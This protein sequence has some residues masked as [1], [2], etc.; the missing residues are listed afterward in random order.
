MGRKIYENSF[1]L[2]AVQHDM[3][4]VLTSTR[5]VLF[6]SQIKKKHYYNLILQIKLDSRWKL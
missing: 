3:L 4:Y 6:L 5:A 2:N 1:T